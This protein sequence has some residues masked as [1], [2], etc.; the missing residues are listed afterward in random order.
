V[1]NMVKR[2]GG[3]V[4]LHSEPGQGS[5]FRVELPCRL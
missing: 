3:R 4:S 1:R 2:L 5:T